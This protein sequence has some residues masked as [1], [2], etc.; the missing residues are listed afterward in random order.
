MIV[1]IDPLVRGFSHEMVNAGFVYSISNDNQDKE[2]LFIAEEGH[3]ECIQDIFESNNYKPSNI[4]YIAKGGVFNSIKISIK[5]RDFSNKKLIEKYIFLSFDAIT[6]SLVYKFIKATPVYLVCHAIFEQLIDNSNQRVGLA[7]TKK[8]ILN[9][10]LNTRLPS[11]AKLI[12]LYAK[13]YFIRYYE[14]LINK[15][16]N[17]KKIFLTQ[18]RS[19]VTY[20]VLSE[21]IISNL[22]KNNVI[23]NNKIIRI[24]MPYVFNQDNSYILN[25]KL[26]NFGVLG[27][28]SPKAMKELVEGVNSLSLSNKYNFW[29]IGANTLGLRDVKN[30]H[31]PI[32]NGFLS[33]EDIDTYSQKL[34]FTLI[35]YDRE[36]YT[37]S[38]SAAIME[39]IMY[40]KP[41]I[42]LDN[43]CVNEFN[44]HDIGIKCDSLSE[45]TEYIVDIVNNPEDYRMQYK[46]YMKNI[47]KLREDL[48]LNNRV[49]LKDS[50]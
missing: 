40:M 32:Q 18:S 37:L 8:D 35:L 20:I 16:F 5:L 7:I 6:V 47:I 24:T 14:V 30:I 44:K 9:K 27:Y 13:N 38:C 49:L 45:L 39:S 36:S 21:H 31:F 3:L 50:M 22:K 10:I 28:G 26:N 15:L 1:I 41:I 33:R 2:I 23:H 17:F 4:K 48:D 46:K 12:L 29:N 19:N 42:Y 25:T 34:D 11:L 43:S